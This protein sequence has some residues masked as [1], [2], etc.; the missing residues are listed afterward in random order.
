MR[1]P[2]RR[3]WFPPDPFRVIQALIILVVLGVAA[4]VI[5]EDVTR[6]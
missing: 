5:I 4:Y 3:G 1:R 2:R 6:R